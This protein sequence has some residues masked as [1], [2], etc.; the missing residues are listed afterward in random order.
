MRSL[1]NQLIRQHSDSRNHL[2]AEAE[3]VHSPIFE[4]A[5]SGKVQA[6]DERLLNSSEKGKRFLIAP[7]AQEAV[8]KAKLKLIIRKKTGRKTS[9]MTLMLESVGKCSYPN[10]ARCSTLYVSDCL[11]GRN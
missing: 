9:S 3:V 8:Q 1:F 6:L 11:A 10:T 2:R 7:T 5:V 4:S